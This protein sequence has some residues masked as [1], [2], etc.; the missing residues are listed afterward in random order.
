MDRYMVENK[1]ETSK[2]R[3]VVAELKSRL[4]QLRT[5]LK[6][7]THYKG[8]GHGL[9]EAL[10][11]VI[12]YCKEQQATDSLVYTQIIATLSHQLQLE[13]QTMANLKKQIEDLQS[14]IQIAYDHMRK[15]PYELFAIWLHQG[16]AGS[17]HYWAYL[18]D[19]TRPKQWIKFNDM[20]V[21]EVEEAVVMRDAFGGYANTSASFLIYIDKNTA[22]KLQEPDPNLDTL[23][24]PQ[25]KVSSTYCSC[26]NS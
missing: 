10:T 25:L 19:F 20:R 6:S 9:D 14:K 4:S 16:I 18:R 1:E 26:L 17:G 5:E 24:P 12:T 7:F 2:Q 22:T 23:V 13:S 11:S 3:L 21:S 15:C 8:S